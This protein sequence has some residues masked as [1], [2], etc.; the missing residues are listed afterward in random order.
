[1]TKKI[2]CFLLAVLTALTFA[3]C[4]NNTESVTESS[5][6]EE[7]E[8]FGNVVDPSAEPS[9]GEIIPDAPITLPSA[10]PS[11]GQ[12][13]EGDT[14][15]QGGDTPVTTTTSPTSTATPTKK[16]S[17]SGGGTTTAT[18]STKP[19]IAPPAPA[20]SATAEEVTA[21]IGKALSTFIAEKGVPISS[22]YEYIDEA[23]PDK[24]EIGTLT[25][26]G[27]VVTTR[28]DAD[29]EIITGVTKTASPSSSPSAEPS[30]SPSPSPTPNTE[31]DPEALN[32]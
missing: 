5:Q 30:A 16:P 7:L 6:M 17:T 20:S 4:G 11:A 22:D 31:E 28:R 3:A 12:F 13:S 19:T 23:D 10:E 2:I 29:G 15:P 8:T 9:A 26:N 14:Q 25:F 27:F 21:Y 24:G 1:M 18:P 32:A